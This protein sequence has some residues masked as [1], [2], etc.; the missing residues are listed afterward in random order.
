MTISFNRFLEEAVLNLDVTQQMT[1]EHIPAVLGTLVQRLRTTDA[2][3]GDGR[4]I[5]AIKMLMM[6]ANSLLS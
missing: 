6:A 4:K 5:K 2:H 3:N 1:A